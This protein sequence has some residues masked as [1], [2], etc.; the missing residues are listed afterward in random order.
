[1]TGFSAEE[2]WSHDILVL[3]AH[4]RGIPAYR[5]EFRSRFCESQMEALGLEKI[6]K[7][8]QSGNPVIV[9][10]SRQFRDKDKFH[11]VVLSGIENSNGEV[12]G[13]YY[14]DPEFTGSE[15]GSHLFVSSSEFS[16]H[17]RKFAIF[18]G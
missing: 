1:M 6:S 12:V 3:L 16:E 9:S 10:V 14:H 18:I 11:Q 8:L 7:V 4:N 13:F 17:W 15:E 5:E 2:G